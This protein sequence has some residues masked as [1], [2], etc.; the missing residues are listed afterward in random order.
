MWI[1]KRKTKEQKEAEEKAGQTFLGFTRELILTLAMALIVIQ[2]VIQAFKIPTSSMEDS[3]MA[4]DF[5]LGLKFIYGAPV[6]PFTYLKFPGFI[7]PK[8][9]DV[10]IFKYPGPEKKDYIKRCV[11]GPGQVLEIRNKELFINGKMVPMP[12]DGKHMSSNIFQEGNPRD[13]FEPVRI[14]RKG[15]TLKLG[16]LSIRDFF[17]ARGVLH[18]ENPRAQLRTDLQLYIDGVYRNQ[19]YSFQHMFRSFR[20]ADINFNIVEWDYMQEIVNSIKKSMPESRIEVKK[21]LYM[22]DNP[23]NEYVL[24]YDCYFMMGDNRDNSKDSRYWGFLS[25]NFVKAKAF[26]LYF[27]YNNYT[28]VFNPVKFV[29][30]SRIGKLIR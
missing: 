27:S 26:I 11:A 8:P 30:W 6:L 14:P 20:F 3:L 17:F 13:N 5:L 24:N 19:D 2:Y 29:R 15:D 4:N 28:S 7:S 18:Q 10:I 1:F 21:F 9:N 25:K 16:S 22:D 23:I 12:P